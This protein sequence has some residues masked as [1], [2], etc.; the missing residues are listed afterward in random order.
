M[1]FGYPQLAV[2]HKNNLVALYY[3]ATKDNPQQHIA[4][5]IWK[6]KR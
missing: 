5:T 3:W 6:H 2:D 1:D 4:E